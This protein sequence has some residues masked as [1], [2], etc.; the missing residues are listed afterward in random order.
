MPGISIPAGR[1]IMKK[2]LTVTADDAALAVALRRSVMRLARRLRSARPRDGATLTQLQILGRLYRHGDCIASTLA[3]EEGLQL[4]SLTRLLAALEAAG[5]ITR[6]QN[7]ADRRQYL[8]AIT[9]AGRS[10]VRRD[11]QARD[12]WLARALGEQLA[13]GEKAALGAALPLLERLLDEG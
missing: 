9:P 6:S 3:A 4:Q 2:R 8:I 12:E 11:M 7:P 1:G 5:W 13:A 10:V